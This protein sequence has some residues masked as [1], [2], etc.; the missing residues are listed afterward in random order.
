MCQICKVNLFKIWLDDIYDNNYGSGLKV[1]Y[2]KEIS[3]TFEERFV[4]IFHSKWNGIFELMKFQ[5][6]EKRSCLNPDVCTVCTIFRSGK[7]A[8]S[9][10][11][12]PCF[13]LMSKVVLHSYVVLQVSSLRIAI[14]R[15]NRKQTKFVIWIVIFFRIWKFESGLFKTLGNSTVEVN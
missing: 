2:L 8:N 6:S 14:R 10:N 5:V 1:W 13:L 15:C 3:V 9:P 11:I 4:N 12:W 7:M